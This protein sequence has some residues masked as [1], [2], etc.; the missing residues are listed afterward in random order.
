MDTAPQPSDPLDVPHDKLIRCADALIDSMKHGDTREQFENR[1]IKFTLT[2]LRAA[3]A[4][5]LRIGI[6]TKRKS[7][8]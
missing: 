4:F 5:L 1:T 7:K 2:E 8:P 6:S 3:E